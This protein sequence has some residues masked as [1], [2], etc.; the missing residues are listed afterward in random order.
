MFCWFFRLMIS[1]AADGH[2]L[3]S[4]LTER[5]L[6]NCASCR[7]F[8]QMCMSLGRDL[9]AEAAV[10]DAG[11]VER[12]NE[13]VIRTLPHLHRK[14]S[15]TAIA[16]RFRP[17]LAAACLALV[18]AVATLFVLKKPPSQD[19]P[20]ATDPV[21]SLRRLVAEDFPIGWARPIETPLDSELRNLT[22]DTESAVRFL[23]ACMAVD[24]IGLNTHQK[25]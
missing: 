17:A 20:Q 18:V 1:G 15:R 19:V 11:N 24:P 7:R 10:S 25:K 21:G 2:E 14:K 12:L 13:Q 3:F 5:H 9:T 6:S 16:I 4:G 22:D 8:Q 23:V